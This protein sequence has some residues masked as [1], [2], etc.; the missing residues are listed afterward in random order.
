MVSSTLAHKGPEERAIAKEQ[1]TDV[2]KIIQ[3]DQTKEYRGTWR[4]DEMTQPLPSQ[5]TYICI[6]RSFYSMS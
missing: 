5:F 1:R 6:Y 3:K 4:K 2:F